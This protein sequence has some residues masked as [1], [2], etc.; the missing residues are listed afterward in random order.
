MADLINKFAKIK[1]LGGAAFGKV[2]SVHTEK[3]AFDG[4]DVAASKENPVAL[5]EL[6]SGQTIAEPV[7]AL[8]VVD[9]KEYSA[10]V[11][12]LIDA[13]SAKIGRPSFATQKEQSAT[14]AKEIETLKA[15][16]ATVQAE[17]AQAKKDLDDEKKEKAKEKEEKEKAVKKADDLE[18]EA[19]KIKK[20]QKSKS[21]YDELKA[22][23]ATTLVGATEAACLAVLGDMP[24][25]VYNAT[26]SA[27]TVGFQK[28]TE[29]R[30]SG[31]PASTDQTHSDETK[32]TDAAEILAKAKMEADASLAT[33]GLS[34]NKGNTEAHA[35][36]ADLLNKNKPAKKNS[37]K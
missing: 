36:V 7:S 13:L 1:V 18:K 3:F 33:A 29:L 19:D 23:E 20:E 21:R 6:P 28:I 2:T 15:S 4:K 11:E 25:A 34:T 32:S 17:L 30:K 27:A 26:K 14:I 16:L 12:T 24:D 37:K 22:I 5:I 10:A 8:T 31:K 35:F 9:D